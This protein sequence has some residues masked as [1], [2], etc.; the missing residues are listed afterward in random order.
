MAQPMMAVAPLLSWIQNVF[1]KCIT[2]R[3][4]S[5]FQIAIRGQ[6]VVWLQ[7]DID[8][9]EDRVVTGRKGQMQLDSLD[10]DHLLRDSILGCIVGLVLKVVLGL[11]LG[12]IVVLRSRVGTSRRMY[13]HFIVIVIIIGI[14]SCLYR[15]MFIGIFIDIFIG[16][17][18]MRNRGIRTTLGGW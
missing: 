1:A 7:R 16:I 14:V 15:S 6:L 8:P 17:G 11:V 4:T 9:I 2:I 18:V 3:T 10:N 12:T 13:N 5:P